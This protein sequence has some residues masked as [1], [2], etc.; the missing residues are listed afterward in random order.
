MLISIKIALE[1]VPKGPIYIIPALVQIMAWCWPGDELYRNQWWLDYRHIYVSL[2]LN[3]LK[4]EDVVTPEAIYVKLYWKIMAFNSDIIWR[5]ISL[6]TA[7]KLLPGNHSSII[8]TI[9]G[10]TMPLSVHWHSYFVDNVWFL[11]MYGKKLIT[12]KY[13]SFE[14][15][16]VFWPQW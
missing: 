1:F 3:E 15:P 4:I 2:G 7:V 13:S 11:Y 5:H 6:L 8:W 10:S 14:I 9:C 12:I 16:I